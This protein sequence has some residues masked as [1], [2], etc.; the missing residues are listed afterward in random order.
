[1]I[2]I[3]MGWFNLSLLEAKRCTP[4]DFELYMHARRFRQQNK[5]EELAM[6]AWLNN[7]VQATKKEGSEYKPYFK[8]FKQ[9]YNSEKEFNSILQPVKQQKQLTSAD[10]NRILSQMRKGELND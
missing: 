9:F 6:Q 1:M 4:R 2:A 10:M 8:N 3:C 7:Q 5:M